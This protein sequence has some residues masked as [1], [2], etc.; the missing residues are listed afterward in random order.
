MIIVGFF[1]V[2]DLSISR[3]LVWRAARFLLFAGWLRFDSSP[4]VERVIRALDLPHN[5]T[6]LVG[7][8]HRLA[9]HPSLFRIVLC[10]NP[11]HRLLRISF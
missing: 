1:R 7:V 9:S 3:A 8:M 10:S 6:A 5:R 4:A 2:R 11:S